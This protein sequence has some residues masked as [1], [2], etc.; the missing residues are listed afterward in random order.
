MQEAL[1]LLAAVGLAIVAAATGASA[2]AGGL[3]SA[4]NCRGAAAMEAPRR[5]ATKSF[6]VSPNPAVE[7]PAQRGPTR[8]RQ[9][10]RGGL[11]KDRGLAGVCSLGAPASRA[12]RHIA[13]MGDSHSAQ[14]RPA[15][16]RVGRQKG[17]NLLSTTA[18]ACDFGGQASPGRACVAWQE[19]VVKW[20]ARHPEVDT[21][22][23]G[24]VAKRDRGAPA[25]Y[26][27][28]WE[29]LPSS[30]SRVIV[31]RDTPA[32]RDDVRACVSRAVARRQAPGS[33]CATRRSQAVRRDGAAVAAEAIGAPRAHA[34]DMSRY[35]CDPARCF[36]VIGGILV[37][38]DGSHMTPQFNLTLAPYLGSELA[39]ALSD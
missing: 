32:A 10:C 28:A 34:I 12:T 35:F 33:A 7:P 19:A 29:R 16:D 22:I 27:R 25:R 23:V 17:W 2:L 26:R 8:N 38:A 37:Y 36:P 3:T 11:R 20:L 31:L 1:A 9:Y 18:S 30:V 14:W 15:L 6:S 39:R 24:Q 21:V 13:V 4:D 5:C